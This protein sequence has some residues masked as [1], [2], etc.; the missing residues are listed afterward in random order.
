MRRRD[1]VAA[2]AAGAISTSSARAQQALRVRRLG[3]LLGGAEGGA[4][5][6]GSR[7]AVFRQALEQLGWRE[8][9]N[10]HID[11]EWASGDPSVTRAAALRLAASAPD[12]LVAGTTFTLKHLQA[13]TRTLPIVFVQVSDPVGQG[14]VDS[15]ARPSG[16]VTG[17]SNLEFSM[18][19]KWLDILK[20]IAPD[21]RRVA[22]MIY[23]TNAASSGWYRTFQELAPKVGVLP[24]SAPLSDATDIMPVIEGLAREPGGGLIVPGDSFVDSPVVR[25]QIIDL[26]A[27]LRVPALYTAPATVA[28]GGLVSYGVDQIAP[29]RLAAGY[30]DRILKGQKP[31]DLPVQ[32]P[33]HFRFAINLKTAKALGLKIPLALQVAA[34]EVIE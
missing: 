4:A 30:V 33:T 31:S 24:I 19:G 13:V 7:F 8:G 18:L 21:T 20:E 10:L 32:R 27:R 14:I 5:T 9:S 23:K 11:L 28:E 15:L 6:Y 2:I 26:V 12:V 29:F 34:D 3:V 25:R 17:F 16:N 1:F 22:L